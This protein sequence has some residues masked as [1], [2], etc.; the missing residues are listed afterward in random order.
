MNLMFD[1][2]DLV[3]NMSIPFA[4]SGSQVNCLVCEASSSKSR[5]F[6]D[7]WRIRNIESLEVVSFDINCK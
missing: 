4:L 6:H 3:V 7:L 1:F 5:S 2:G